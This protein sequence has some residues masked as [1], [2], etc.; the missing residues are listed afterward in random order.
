M[1]FDPSMLPGVAGAAIGLP[2]ILLWGDQLLR[3]WKG[4]GRW[5]RGGNIAGLLFFTLIYGAWVDAWF[6]EPNTIVVRQVEVVSEQWRGAPL[7]IAAIGDT[8]VGGPH[9]SVSRVQRIV[10]QINS[11]H[12]DLVVLLGDYANGHQHEAERTPEDRAQ[13]LGGIAIFAALNAQYGVVSVIGNHDV[14]YGRESITQALQD[15]GVGT[16]WNRNI[17]IHRP[18]GDVVVAGLED[19]MTSHPDFS[20]ALD[21][22]PYGDDTIVLS[23]SP[24]PFVDIPRPSGPNHWAPALMLSGHGHCGQVTIPLIGR[25]ILPLRNKRFQCHRTDE[26]GQTLYETAGIG[27][28]IAPVR[29]LNPPEIVLITIRSAAAVQPP[30]PT[31]QQREEGGSGAG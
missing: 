2:I 13:V 28:S 23:H 4:A 19:D 21:G 15:A 11:M 8:H 3:R 24:D 18:G 16:L 14:W 12:P 26:H 30:A 27:T 7:R 9:V 1:H 20:E 25:P 10:M 5:T 6:I 22:A 29:F 17:V 31:Q